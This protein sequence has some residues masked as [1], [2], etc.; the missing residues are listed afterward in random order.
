MGI[1]QDAR[2]LSPGKPRLARRSVLDL[3]AYATDLGLALL[4]AV[5]SSWMRSPCW[6]RTRLQATALGWRTK[7]L[8]GLDREH[9]AG[10]VGAS[11]L[12]RLSHGGRVIEINDR[13]A[14]IRRSA[15]ALLTHRRTGVEG[16]DSSVSRRAARRGRSDLPSLPGIDT[17]RGK[18]SND[19]LL[20]GAELFYCQ[21]LQPAKEVR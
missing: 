15:T 19:G 14:H 17:K 8:F 2:G 6:L 4:L 21:P 5:R 1:R 3:S 7:E 13:L 12:T 18:L 9:A 16:S 11:G 10:H 20:T